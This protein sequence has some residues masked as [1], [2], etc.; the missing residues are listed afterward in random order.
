MGPFYSAVYKIINNSPS[1]LCF[2]KRTEQYEAVHSDT[3]F[4][5]IVVPN[6]NMCCLYSE[7]CDFIPSLSSMLL[8]LRQHCPYTGFE[9]PF[10]PSRF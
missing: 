1:A 9:S 4:L 6:V 5:Q 3:Y 2:E 7:N 10:I 8:Q